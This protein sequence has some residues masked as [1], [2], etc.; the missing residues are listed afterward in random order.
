MLGPQCVAFKLAQAEQ[1]R[2]WAVLLLAPAQAT[3]QQQQPK[4]RHVHMHHPQLQACTHASSH[5]GSQG[6]QRCLRDN[7][8][9]AKLVGLP[10]RLLGVEGVDQGIGHISYIAGLPSGSAAPYE[11]ED[12]EGLGH[13][14]EGVVQAVLVANHLPWLEDGHIR[15]DVLHRLLASSLSSSIVSV[16]ASMWPTACTWG[17]KAQAPLHLAQLQVQWAEPG[18]VLLLLALLLLAEGR[19]GGSNAP[20]V[21]QARMHTSRDPDAMRQHK[22]KLL[23][24]PDH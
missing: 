8:R 2:T 24:C 9:P 19:S 11:G 12:G 22:L 23:C 16:A 15:E 18:L 5:P 21:P 10:Q 17:S 1:L 13:A 4:C 3:Q 7:L 6:L 20:P 14:R